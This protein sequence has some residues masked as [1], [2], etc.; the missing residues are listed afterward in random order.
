VLI[1][2]ADKMNYT[3]TIAIMPKKCYRFVTILTFFVILLS[4]VASR[5][6]LFSQTQLK[7][8]KA[9]EVIP[10]LCLYSSIQGLRWLYNIFHYQSKL[11]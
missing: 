9:Y 11:V 8:F 7:N 5:R 10:Y 6:I 1:T 3:K 2:D 4:F